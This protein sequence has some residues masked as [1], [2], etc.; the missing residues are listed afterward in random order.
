MQQRRLLSKMRDEPGALTI[1]Y[2]ETSHVQ[3]LLPIR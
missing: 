1:E 3:Q 2:Y